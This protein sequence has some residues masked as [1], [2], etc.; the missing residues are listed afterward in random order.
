MAKNRDIVPDQ[1][2]DSASGRCGYNR[3][4]QLR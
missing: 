1:L 2:G 4:A 3:L